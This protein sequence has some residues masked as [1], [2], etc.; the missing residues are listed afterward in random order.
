MTGNPDCMATLDGIPGVHKRIFLAALGA[1]LALLLAA[2]LAASSDWSLAKDRKGIQLYTR[3]VAGSPFEEVKAT[4]IIH[5]PIERVIAV[6]G[7]GA[8]CAK[9]RGNC[10]SS[11][12]LRQP[13]EHERYIHMVLDLPWPLSDRDMVLRSL[14]N[15]DETSKTATVDIVSV[16][17]EYPE[18]KYVRANTRAHYSMELLEPGK[19]ALTYIVHV[20]LG[21]DLSPGIINPELASSTFDE[22]R[23]LVE[24]AE[25]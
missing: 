7:D 5:A 6:F 21:G 25:G 13:Q 9:W 24:L 2:P 16:E 14:S 22:I 23:R 20:D 15:V 12:I 3:P 11:R 18:Q 8:T 1:L 17:G 10:K 4:T 19:I